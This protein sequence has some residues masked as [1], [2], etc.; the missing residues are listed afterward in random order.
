MQIIP[1]PLRLELLHLDVLPPEQRRQT[2]THF[3]D[4]FGLNAAEKQ[5]VLDSVSGDERQRLEKTLASIGRLPAEQR[6]LAL[7]TLN[8]L[9][10]CNDKQREEFLNNL[11]RWKQLSPEERQLWINLTTILPP[12]PPPPLPPLPSRSPP[13]PNLSSATNPSP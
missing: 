1:P 9:A 2:Y 10:G 12:L 11:A 8:Q 6:D 13:L 4:F 3:Q 7:R 5:A